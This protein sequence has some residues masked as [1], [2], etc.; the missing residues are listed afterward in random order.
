M[1]KYATTGDGLLTAI[2]LTEEVCDTKLSLSKLCQDVQVYP[3]FLKNLRVK[4]KQAV[5]DEEKVKEVVGE[6]ED[7]INGKGRVLLRQS[8]TE[9]VIRVMVECEREEDCK[10]YVEEIANVIIERGHCE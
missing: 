10:T 6:I 9:P 7:K 2:M 5:V 8:G 4:N 1:K 3:Q